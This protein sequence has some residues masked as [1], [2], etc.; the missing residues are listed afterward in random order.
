M[1]REGMQRGE[2]PCQVEAIRL[3]RMAVCGKAAHNLQY[4]LMAEYRTIRGGR[5]SGVEG[6]GG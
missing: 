2:P 1:R 3:G 5:A 4:V 6:A